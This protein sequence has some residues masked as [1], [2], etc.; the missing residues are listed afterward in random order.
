[1][2]QHR[3]RTA[4]AGGLS[5]RDL[6]ARTGAGGI[7]GVLGA[8]RPARAAGRP[9]ATIRVAAA[10]PAGAID[11]VTV[12]DI[13]GLVLLQQTGE[14]LVYDAPALTLRPML[15]LSW[16][17]NPKGDVWTFRLR[18]GVKF[19]SGG[20]M[21]ADDV[22]A[23]M[24][25]LADPKNGSNALSVFKGVLSPGGTQKLDDHTVAFHLD[26]PA[27]HFPYYVSSDNYNAIILPASYKGDFEKTFDGTGPFRLARYTPNAGA[28]FVANREWWGGRVLP[29]RVEFGLYADQQS[30]I[31]AMQ[32][33]QVDVMQ[34]LTVQGG[35]ALLNNPDVRLIKLR[36]SIHRQVH[37]RCDTGPFADKRV[38]QALAL[39]LDRPALAA[40]LFHGL[41]DLGND[42][43]FAPVYPSTDPS[44][45][46][47][48][49][50]IARAKSLMAAAGHAHGFTVTLTTERLQEIPDY[51]VLIRNAAKQI[52]ITVNLKVETQAA[53]YGA[54]K[55]GQS[56][57][58]NSALGI[59]DYGHRGVPDALLLATLGSDG[60]WNAAHFRN[61]AYDKLVGDY[62]A[63]TGLAA[64]RSI[65]GRIEALLLD[66]TPVIFAYFYNYLIATGADVRGVEGTAIS[67]LFLQS[68]SIG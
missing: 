52:G 48:T 14:F 19:H 47:R 26:R 65:A 31:L 29:A 28:S 7:A 49:K 3:D 15:A 22:V 61:P 63:T 9:G 2:G 64:Q 39:T 36:S 18:Q 41:S 27:G 34:Q 38:R 6:L 42:S 62:V 54:A 57:W 66:E 68:A 58:L 1:M 45:P 21:V 20:T 23:T 4:A 10:V 46:Q 56:D 12:A 53:Y 11:P 59:T 51:A 33:Q 25:R 44:V 17:P 32:G 60:P 16:E 67:Q 35:Q 50:D 5:R 13:G 37:M 24:D 8:A 40:G 55:F 30:Q 43:P